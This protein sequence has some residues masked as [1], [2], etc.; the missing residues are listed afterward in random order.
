[1][2]AFCTHKISLSQKKVFGVW[3]AFQ[4]DISILVKARMR[5]FFPKL[6]ATRYLSVSR[7]KGFFEI[8]HDF[9][10]PIEDIHLEIIGY[11]KITTC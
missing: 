1:M 6:L 4:S 10:F 5:I 9:F 7:Y 3:T 8:Y 2:G 11:A